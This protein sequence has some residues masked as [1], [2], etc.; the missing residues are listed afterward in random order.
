MKT[1]ILY[2]TKSGAARE[3]ACRLAQKMECSA[4]DLK[5][6]IPNLENFDIIIIG[7]GIR[8]GKAYKPFSKFIKQ[9][10]SLLL[11][12]KTAIYFCNAYPDTFMKAVEK[13]LP[14]ELIEHSGCIKSFGGKAPFTASE[15]MDWFRA[16]EAEDLIIKCNSKYNP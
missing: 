5:E 3:C 10:L 15:S 13:N 2:A 1:I 9:N 14:S 4:Y 16:E 12:K 8:M 6:H 7:T 11:S